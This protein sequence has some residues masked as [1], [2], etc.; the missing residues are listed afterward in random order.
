MSPGPAGFFLFLFRFLC[1]S[2]SA[3]AGDG[4]AARLRSGAEACEDTWR[5][6]TRSGRWRPLQRPRRLSPAPRAAPRLPWRASRSSCLGRRL[7]AAAL[8]GRDVKCDVYQHYLACS[9]SRSFS[10][11]L[12][13][14]CS[15]RPAAR[16]LR[17]RSWNSTVACSS[18]R[19]PLPSPHSCRGATIGCWGRRPQLLGPSSPA[20]L[21]FAPLAGR[22]LHARIHSSW[23]AR[24][25][26]QADNRAPSR[27]RGAARPVGRLV[28]AAC[29]P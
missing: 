5:N 17:A 18:P 15:A 9:L 19:S 29:P 22:S 25:T 23:L 14:R 2:S 27:H 12:D 10:R 20:R 8:R 11:T 16:T 1:W 21:R 7:T 24:S 13:S 6:V 26:V 3:I 28:A 4:S